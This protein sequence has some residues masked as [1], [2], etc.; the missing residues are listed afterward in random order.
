MI[1]LVIKKVFKLP[2]SLLLLV[3]LLL[4]VIP[5]FFYGQSEGIH[6]HKQYVI[7]PSHYFI[8]FFAFILL[9]YW[10]MYMVTKDILLTMYLTWL[11]MVISIIIIVFLVTLRAW[12][13]KYPTTQVEV[14]LARLL[15]ENN[16]REI[17]ISLLWKVIFIAGQLAY[18]V[19]LTGGLIKNHVATPFIN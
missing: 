12:V 4:A 3:S 1:P 6:F 8:W 17:K 5:L 11:H 15:L 13:F 9:L 16:P 10:I 2:Y 14:I 7:I 18:V 19:N